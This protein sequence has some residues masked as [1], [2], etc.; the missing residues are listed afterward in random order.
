M[1]ESRFYAEFRIS[2]H[3]RYYSTYLNC[4]HSF[5]RFSKKKKKKKKQESKQKYSNFRAINI[6]LENQ[7]GKM[8][9]R[10]E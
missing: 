4:A 9:F 5:S 8:R 7:N 2:A 3:D 10:R 6:L 1:I